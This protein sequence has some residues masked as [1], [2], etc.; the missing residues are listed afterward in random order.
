MIREIRFRYWNTTNNKMVNDPVIP[1][2]RECDWT[3]EQY[4]SERGWVWMQYT[5]LEDNTGQDIY[6][7]DIINC[8]TELSTINKEVEFN[9]GI[10]GVSS[11]SGDYFIP[12][13]DLN[14]RPVVVGNIYQHPELLTNK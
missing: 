5:G 6:E 10:F 14:G 8:R 12:L 4:F 7:G 9:N 2:K 1:T 11:A 3:L 13:A